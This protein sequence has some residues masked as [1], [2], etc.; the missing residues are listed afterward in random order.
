L[1]ETFL[2]RGD[3]KLKEGVFTGPQICEIMMDLLENLLTET[4]KSTWLPFKAVCLNLFGNVKG[5]NYKE[6][7][8]DLLEVYQTIG[9]NISLKIHFLHSYLDLFPRDL[10]A[11]SD[12]HGERSRRDISTMEKIYAG[13][14]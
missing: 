9:R 6:L 3:A 14:S 13:K 7:V 8:E 1:R 4:E 12:E 10:C 2:E 11:V 5:E